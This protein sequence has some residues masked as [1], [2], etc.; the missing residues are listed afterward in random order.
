MQSSLLALVSLLG[1]SLAG[2]ITQPATA[3]VPRESSL[4]AFLTL[5]LNYLPAVGGTLDDV[6][7]TIES[8]ENDLATL[9]G[10]Q[11]TYNELSN[12]C[13]TYTLIFARGTTEP[14]NVGI[15]VGPPF[16]DALKSALGSTTINVQ[17][18]NDYSASITG[19]VAG[20]DATGSAEMA[21]QIEQA[22]ASCP[23]TKLVAAGYSQGAQLGMVF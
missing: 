11:I 16:I 9:T 8:F 10:D 20:G 6:A 14:G 3:L 21:T 17:G 15:L 1:F 12:A 23:K 2:P 19:Y 7:D 4:N 18:V 13:A 5:L 22:Y